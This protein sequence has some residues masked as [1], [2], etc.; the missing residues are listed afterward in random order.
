MKLREKADG[1]YSAPIVCI[2]S[3]SQL[4]Q[5]DQN[6]EKQYLSSSRRGLVPNLIYQSKMRT[7]TGLATKPLWLWLQSF[8]RPAVTHCVM[9]PGWGQA[10]SLSETNFRVDKSWWNHT[11]TSW[12]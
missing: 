4:F 7:R 2:L 6:V 5:R 11:V 10:C 1:L 9:C 12:C 8:Q 3:G